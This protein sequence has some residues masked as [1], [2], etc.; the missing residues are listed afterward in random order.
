MGST[1]LEPSLPSH[2]GASDRTQG[3]VNGSQ[4]SAAHS[5]PPRLPIALFALMPSPSPPAGVFGELHLGDPR[6][7]TAR[8]QLLELL[9][10]GQAVVLHT[11]VPLCS[12]SSSAAFPE[13]APGSPGPKPPAGESRGGGKAVWQAGPG[14]LFSRSFHQGWGLMTAMLKQDCHEF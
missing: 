6:Q 10:C 13:A 1:H 7:L 3:L 8:S 11:D 14:A 9:S 5:H 12:A 4:S 2:C